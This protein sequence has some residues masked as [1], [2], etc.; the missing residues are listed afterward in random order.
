M[1]P[2][3]GGEFCARKEWSYTQKNDVAL[4][5]TGD[6]RVRSYFKFYVIGTSSTSKC[7]EKTSYFNYCAL[8]V[9][10]RLSM[11]INSLV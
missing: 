6:V 4:T 7:A 1:L 2:G 8:Y 3:L 11:T 9:T 5:K 10:L